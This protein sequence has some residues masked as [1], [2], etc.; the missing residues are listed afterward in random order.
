MVMHVYTLDTDQWFPDYGSQMK[1]THK[2]E[3]LSH[4]LKKLGIWGLSMS[5]FKKQKGTNKREI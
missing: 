4:T 1:G 5:Y 2:R 3:I